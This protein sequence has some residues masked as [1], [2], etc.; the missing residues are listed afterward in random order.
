[1]ADAH[2][3]GS[4]GGNP[5]EVQVLFQARYIVIIQAQVVKLVYTHP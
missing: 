4:C 2:D 3:S 1:M 5:L